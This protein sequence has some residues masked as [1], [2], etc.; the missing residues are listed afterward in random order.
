MLILLPWALCAM[1][2]GRSGSGWDRRAD[3]R[4]ADMIYLE[5][6]RARALDRHDDTYYLIARAY[7]LNP[8]DSYVG[9]LYG[10]FLMGQ[11]D[12]VMADMGYNLIR[13]YVDS[14]EGRND[15][16]PAYAFAQAAQRSGRTDEALDM[17]RRLYH[18]YPDREEMAMSYAGAMM[19]EAKTAD[20]MRQVVALLDTIE[21]R[22]GRSPE[23][24]AR[25]AQLYMNLG[26]TANA[27]STVKALPESNPS[28]PLYLLMT[29]QMLEDLEDDTQVLDYYNRAIDLVPNS[30]MPRFYLA[31]YYLQKGDSIGY[32]REVFNALT[33]PD[34]PVEDKL[35]LISSYVMS[36]A[37][38]PAMMDSIA[39][40][41]DRIVEMHPHEA[42]IH[43]VYCEFLLMRG[44]Y[45]HAAEQ[46]RYQL[47]L[48]PSEERR[49]VQL[50]QMQLM[51]DH[52]AEALDVATRGLHFY[53]D[54]VDLQIAAATADASLGNVEQAMHR[55]DSLSHAVTV[56]KTLSRVYTAAGD[57][58]YAAAQRDSA[59]V[60]YNMAIGLDPENATAMN[61]CA[62]FLACNDR[63][64]DRAVQ[65]I[66]KAI[67][68]R[69][70][71]PTSLDTYA[72]VLFKR[73]DYGKAREIIDMTL[74]LE[75]QPTAELLEHAGDIYFMDRENAQAVDFW[76][77]ALQL[78]PDN[79]LL[80][81]KV[82]HKTYF[83]Q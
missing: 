8:S 66:E 52:D 61:N 15:F 18:D 16:Y 48:D 70:D 7:E 69:P 3:M 75:P 24:T 1:A 56:P 31:N 72:W 78:D 62:Y 50:A 68:L 26:D 11:N 22:D 60:Y 44:D 39:G 76:T 34:V 17:L 63:D 25:K 21:L 59:F 64:L 32:S 40:L 20:D 43:A 42:P 27:V 29:A 67:E 36:A 83:Y 45:A 23:S 79:E 19:S 30:G 33:L 81:R 73:K 37:S 13:R 65:L 28:N 57:L 53:K 55:I 80:G 71:D 77:R 51:L 5:A 14:P 46:A 9:W 10:S 74:Q 2:A 4:K 58:L 35:E 12:S 49:W 38:D 41:F 47:D 54:N 82:R 6:V